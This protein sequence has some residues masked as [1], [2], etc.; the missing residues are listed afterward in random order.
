MPVLDKLA[1]TVSTL[2]IFTPAVGHTWSPPTAKPLA[3]AINARPDQVGKDDTPIP[4]SPAPS[5]NRSKSSLTLKANTGSDYQQQKLLYDTYEMCEK[6][7]DEY[8]DENPLVGEPGN[9]RIN[10]VKEVAVPKPVLSIQTPFSAAVSGKSSDSPV[11]SKKAKTGE[12]TPISAGA[13]EK[14]SRRKSKAAGATATT[15]PK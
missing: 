9:F 5:V 15:T 4:G 10:K 1:S 11:A 2:P 12:K 7:G 8:M 6:Y 13:K 14:K 3:A